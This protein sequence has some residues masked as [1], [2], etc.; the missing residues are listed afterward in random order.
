MPGIPSLLFTSAVPHLRPRKKTEPSVT[1]FVRANSNH[2]YMPYSPIEDHA[3]IGNLHTIALVNLSGSI[4]FLCLPRFDSPSVFA[5]ILDDKKG[6]CF[7]FFCEDDNIRFKQ[8][9][10]PGT[11]ILITRYLSEKGIAEVTD[12]MPIAK[13]EQDFAIYRR[14]KAV[15]GDHSIKVSINPRFNYAREKC[16]VERKEDKSGYLIHDPS[17]KQPTL[18]LSTPHEFEISED[19]LSGDDRPQTRRKCRLPAHA[20]RR[21]EVLLRVHAGLPGVPRVL[22]QLV[23]QMHLSGVV[24]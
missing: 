11:N 19:G 1:Y 7:T 18:Y 15:Y 20:G 17:G 6:G 24:A 21:A 22:D 9:Y 23:R 14:L 13:D 12:F 16:R 5:R 3:V 8:L 2:L 10:L 4:D